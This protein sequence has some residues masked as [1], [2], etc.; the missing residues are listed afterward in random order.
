MKICLNLYISLVDPERLAELDVGDEK[1]ELAIKVQQ[2]NPA[3]IELI[4][5]MSENQNGF[6]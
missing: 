1:R 2:E 4:C 5:H 6:T 3:T